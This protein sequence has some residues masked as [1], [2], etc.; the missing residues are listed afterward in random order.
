VNDP[1]IFT[2]G[3]SCSV[4]IVI[5]HSLFVRIERLVARANMDV[6]ELVELALSD[7]FKDS[8][9]STEALGNMI[10]RLADGT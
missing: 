5:D 10:W 9:M 6:K 4:P 3:H 8:D 1:V 2:D 7:I